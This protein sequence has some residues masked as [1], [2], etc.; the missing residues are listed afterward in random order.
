LAR[1]F[2]I[3]HVIHL[4]ILLAAIHFNN[5]ELPLLRLAP[6]IITYMIILFTPLV[7][8]GLFFSNIPLP[9][10]E[11][12]FVVASGLLFL[13]TY[14]ARISGKSSFATGSR[15]SYILFGS[16]TVIL[17]L[18]FVFRRYITTHMNR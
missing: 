12:V 17:L 3:V 11:R 4:G 1:N 13:F 8:R 10:V 14:A 18:C 2:A 5:M 6:G 9:V 7:Y 16:G 15:L